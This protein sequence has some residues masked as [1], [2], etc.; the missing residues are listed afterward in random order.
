M[1]LLT[2]GAVVPVPGTHDVCVVHDAAPHP[3]VAA[4]CQHLGP[5]H[6]PCARVKSHHG[7]HLLVSLPQPDTNIEGA[8][9][10]CVVS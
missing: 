8:G 4:G 5:D 3:A 6:R 9:S 7:W 10:L 1:A 2:C